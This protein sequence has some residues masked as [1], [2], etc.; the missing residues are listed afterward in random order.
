MSRAFDTIDRSKLMEILE[1]VPDITDD[2]RRL[3]RLLLANTSIQVNFNGV[4]TE[5]FVS[6][7]GSPQGD[8]LS[9]ILFAIYLEAAVREFKARGPAR[10]QRD[11]DVDLP[12]EAIYA[13][14]TDFIS[15][16]SDF[17]DEIQECIGPIFKEFNLLVNV[18]K[19]ERITIGH[20]DLSADQ[21][22]RTTRKLGSLLGVE[23]DVNR[24][25]QLAFQALN[26]LEAMWKHRSLVAQKIRVDA[27]RALV[28]SVLMYNCG[29][30]ALTE[31]LSD[32]LD[33][34]QRKMIRRVLGLKWSDRVTNINLYARCGI[35]PA[36][37]QVVNARWR[38]FGHTLRMNE[39]SPARKAMAFY[40]MHDKSMSG[41]GGNRVTLPTALSN[42]YYSMFGKYVKT[43]AEYNNLVRVAQ[44]RD[45]WKGVVQLVVAK[46]KS[47]QEAKVLLKTELRHAAKNRSAENIST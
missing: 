31:A 22:Y 38:L 45:A 14:D 28:E 34:C 29:T 1:T 10:P 20:Q 3:I 30:W 40:F 33:R 5:P 15:M 41:R 11:L 25:I 2:D 17:L 21:S 23:E 26:K 4:V 27:Y 13:D 42:D 36:S 7:I 37:L 24:R 16:F 43:S 19:T 35:S 47:N 18:D 12:L 44:N 6:T 46:Y 9:P 32:K 39:G 8:A